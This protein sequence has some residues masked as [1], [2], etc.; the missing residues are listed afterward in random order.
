MN[1]RDNNHVHFSWCT[2]GPGE[3]MLV[4]LECDCRLQSRLLL[5]GIFFRLNKAE[6]VS[7]AG[8]S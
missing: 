7:A 2:H 3:A 4:L 5:C 6:T 8:T 1:L